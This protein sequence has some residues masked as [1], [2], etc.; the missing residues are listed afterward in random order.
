MFH[1]KDNQDKSIYVERKLILMIEER[2]I[3]HSEYLKDAQSIVTVSIDSTIIRNRKDE[4]TGLVINNKALY[5]IESAKTLHT[6][7]IAYDNIQKG[8]L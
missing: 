8:Y 5:S 6:R 3:T 7:L 1:F 2:D 4:T